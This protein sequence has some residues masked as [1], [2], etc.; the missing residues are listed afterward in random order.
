MR[1]RI[2]LWN[3]A[4]KMQPQTM[5]ALASA[6]KS[7]LGYITLGLY[8]E[9]WDELESLP[10]EFRATDEVIGLRIEIYQLLGKWQSAR[11]LAESMAKRSPENPTWWI[12]WAN[13]QRHET[14]TLEGRWVLY[15]AIQ[16]HPASAAVLYSLACFSCSLGE[17]KKAQKLLAKAIA[18]DPK[19][20]AKALDE[21]DL[22]AI[23]HGS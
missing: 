20:T 19:L 23:F 5:P 1:L 18:I 8:Q 21:P 17:T 10:P 15:Q 6:L 16:I 22:E 9:A 13:S 2:D 11:A 12:A 14:C 7:S 3:R 4:G